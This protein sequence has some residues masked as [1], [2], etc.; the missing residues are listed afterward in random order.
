MPPFSSTGIKSAVRRLYHTI[1]PTARAANYARAH[2]RLNLRSVPK[3][4]RALLHETFPSLSLRAHELGQPVRIVRGIHAGARRSASVASPISGLGAR[5]RPAVRQVRGAAVPA[6]VG[7]HPS[8]ARMFSST[9]TFREAA[10]VNVPVGFRALA[11]GLGLIDEDAP[12]D[13]RKA[14]RRK[15]I[16]KGYKGADRRRRYTAIP[17]TVSSSS[18]SPEELELYFPSPEES[19]LHTAG[20]TTYLVLPLAPSLLHLLQ[21]ESHTPSLSLSYEQTSIATSILTSRLTA[22][23]LPLHAL[24]TSHAQE[25]VIPLLHR[26]DSVNGLADVQLDVVI[27]RANA[28]YGEPE[29]LRLAFPERSSDDVRAL[30]GPSYVVAARQGQDEWFSMYQ[31]PTGRR[32]ARSSSSDSTVSMPTPPSSFGDSASESDVE[33]EVESILSSPVNEWA[34]NNAVSSELILPTLDFTSEAVSAWSSTTASPAAIAPFEPAYA[35]P[36]SWETEWRI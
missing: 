23:L 21:L 4:A 26:L 32:P 3:H 22:D 19:T 2:I 24:F 1:S 7:L 13:T 15:R 11:Y 5:L 29:A 12:H 34:D 31:V 36:G 30:L 35:L 28:D 17:R 8:P 18:S 9:G 14:L 20:T 10:N 16:V 27:S 33:M 25:R 6:H